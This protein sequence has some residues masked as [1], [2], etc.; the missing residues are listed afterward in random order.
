MGTHAHFHINVSTICRVLSLSCLLS[1][2]LSLSLWASLS[3]FFFLPPSVLYRLTHSLCPPQA[4]TGTR[5]FA[6]TVLN[7]LPYNE[8]ALIWFALYK[9]AFA[10][11]LHFHLCI[12]CL[13]PIYF[14]FSIFNFFPPGHWFVCWCSFFFLLFFFI[15]ILCIYELQG[16]LGTCAPL[17][18]NCLAKGKKLMFSALPQTL[19]S[20]F[21]FFISLFPFHPSTLC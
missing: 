14:I 8:P 20:A 9:C 15:I 17:S 18:E 1:L 6:Q 5:M 12:L 16:H 19:F 11:C 4:F 13:L 10:F 3:P 2:S 7:E 21:L